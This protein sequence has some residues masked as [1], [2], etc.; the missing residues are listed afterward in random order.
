MA[1]FHSLLEISALLLE[2]CHPFVPQRVELLKFKHVGFFNTKPL[3]NLSATHGF[4]SPVFLMLPQLIQ[5][6]LRNFGFYIFSLTLAVFS[7]FF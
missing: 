1:L 2:L 5:A 4:S 3:R 6:V 7:V